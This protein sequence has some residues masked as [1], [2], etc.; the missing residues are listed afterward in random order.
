MKERYAGREDWH[1]AF[2]L[3]S[4]VGVFV[5]LVAQDAM[6]IA[7]VLMMEGKGTSG[8]RADTAGLGRD[9][10]RICKVVRAQ[11]AVG[12]TAD[13][14]ELRADTGGGS[15]VMLMGSDGVGQGGQVTAQRCILGHAGTAQVR[16]KGIC[17]VHRLGHVIHGKAVHDC[18]GTI[19]ERRV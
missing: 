5:V 6:T 2:Y 18:N 1:T 10:G 19:Q 11:L 4:F 16:L 12:A 8:N 13:V 3:F 17:D 9:A 15:P 14:A 7:A